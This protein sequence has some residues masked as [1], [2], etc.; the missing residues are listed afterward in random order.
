MSLENPNVVYIPLSPILI[1]LL[2]NAVRSG[3]ITLS[4][5]AISVAHREE[6]FLAWP[7]SLSLSASSD[8]VLKLAE[9]LIACLRIPFRSSSDAL[10]ASPHTTPSN[11]AFQP[12]NSP[13]SIIYFLA[14]DI[15][16]SII[17]LIFFDCAPYRQSSNSLR[18][19]CI[20]LNSDA[21][22]IATTATVTRSPEPTIGSR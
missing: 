12:I 2:R 19:A 1:F 4:C 9:S 18:I 11:G 20:T 7:S 21:A 15:S 14:E 6:Y 5:S 3:L 13:L 16:Q 22:P 17:F 8:N 10:T